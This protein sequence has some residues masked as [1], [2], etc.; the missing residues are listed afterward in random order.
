[1]L[2]TAMRHAERNGEHPVALAIVRF[3]LL[4][5]FRISEGQ[6]LKRAWLH[7]DAGYV[8]FPDTKGDAQIRSI[9][10]AAAKL[11]AGQPFR[12][13]C[14]YVF[15]AD[16]GDG[17]FTAAKACLSR[18]CASVGIEGITPH[19]LRHTFGS[20]AGDLGFS[21]L[22]IRALLGHAAQSVT[23]G[24]VHIDEAL[25]LAVTRTCGEIAAL[26]ESSDDQALNSEADRKAA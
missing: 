23:Q 7:A 5:G 16:F 13:N 18:L 6:G 12:P 2:G 17:Y 3:L 19:T 20:V 1:M 22:T 24:Y 10:P 8:S 26:L 25:K 4:T 21:E 9:G 15:P 11:A 14:P